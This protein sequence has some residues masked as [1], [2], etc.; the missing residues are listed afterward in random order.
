MGATREDQEPYH[1]DSLGDNSVWWDWTA[2][3]S[4]KVAFHTRG[5]DFDTLLAVYTGTSLG[6]LTPVASD[7]GFATNGSIADFTA[8]AG[9]VYHIAVDGWLGETGQI[10]LTILRPPVNDSFAS[11]VVLSGFSAI[12]TGTN[13][14]AS[15]EPNEPDH[16][17]Y[18]AEH[19][20]WWTW[21]APV[22]GEVTIT[23][24]E[25]DFQTNLGVYTG[26]SLATLSRVES[27]DSGAVGLSLTFLATAGTTYQIAV[28]GFFGAIGDISLAIGYAPGEYV[29]WDGGGDGASWADPLNWS[30]D[31]VPGPTNDVSI[32]FWEDPLIQLSGGNHSIRSLTCYE[33]LTIS[34]GTLEIAQD[35]QF[36]G[37]TNLSGGQITGSG[38]ITVNGVLNWTGGTIIGGGKIIISNAAMLNMSGN[39]VLLSNRGMEIDGNARMQRSGD[40]VLRTSALTLGTQASLDL[41]DNSMIVDYT[42]PSALSLIRG[43]I[44]NGFAAGAW[45]GDGINSSVAATT[46][47][48]A[49]GIAEATDAGI[50]PGSPFS[51]EVIDTTA[52]LV[53]YTINGDA[54]LDAAADLADLMIV[55]GN[56]N[57]SGKDFSH[58]DFNYDGTVNQLDLGI[59]A[60]N[61]MKTPDGTSLGSA[62]MPTIAGISQPPQR[63][64]MQAF[65]PA[66][67]TPL[68]VMDFVRN[69][70]NVILR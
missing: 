59:L 61:W 49:I 54:N 34:G 5:S 21:T 33:T 28:D 44:V 19:S 23:P 22:S 47:N 30:A 3:F 69:D 13:I 50:S 41:A 31:F 46:P 55:A 26:S 6:S 25:S 39:G 53:R 67:Q 35:S 63:S 62:P 36:N 43:Y 40:L 8:V 65:R 51:G 15:A 12:A 9:T 66:V 58:G 42:G 20:V 11:R 24:Y 14:C 27:D 57:S 60:E 1:A 18:A 64:V 4:G 2:P 7:N 48:R 10:Q 45:N 17:G 29:S 38:D 56:W 16:A 32:L 68:R 52:V 70:A 37:T